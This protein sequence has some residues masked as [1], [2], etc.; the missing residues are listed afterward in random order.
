MNL[1]S[2]HPDLDSLF[3]YR[4]G[5][6]PEA[7]LR[8]I[9]GHLASCGACRTAAQQL[10]GPEP[11]PVSEVLRL[12]AQR[13]AELAQ[14]SFESLKQRVVREL[15]PYLGAL[16][17]ERVLQTLPRTGENLLSTLDSTLRLFIGKSAASQLVSRIVDRA[18]MRP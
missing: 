5:E 13:Q 17:A 12:L 7:Q 8:S 11:P 10:R 9:E 14:D 1:P 4:A 3:R 16:A 18:I 15:T 2:E 6:L